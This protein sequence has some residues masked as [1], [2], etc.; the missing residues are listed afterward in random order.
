MQ[1]DNYVWNT[2]LH[3]HFT[4]IDFVCLF[5]SCCCSVLFCSCFW[6]GNRV[7]VIKIIYVWTINLPCSQYSIV[8][9]MRHKSGNLWTERQENEKSMNNNY[10]PVRNVPRNSNRALTACYPPCTFLVF[11]T[12]R[13][14]CCHGIRTFEMWSLPKRLVELGCQFSLENRWAISM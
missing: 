13:A 3:V 10:I 11:Q 7:L 1:F 8:I 12:V 6:N 14:I 2:R 5:I 4:I 9:S